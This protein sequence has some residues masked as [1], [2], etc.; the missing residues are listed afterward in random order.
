MDKQH[1]LQ[2]TIPKRYL[3]Q[4]E[5]VKSVIDPE[6]FRRYN[7]GIIQASILRACKPRELNYFN[8][9][10]LSSRMLTILKSTFVPEKTESCD[11]LI[12]FLYALAIGKLKLIK[13]DHNDFKV[14]V[15]DHFSQN[16]WVEFFAR[17]L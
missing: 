6:N 5:H 3:I 4:H 7:D 8:N 9:E 1:T 10:E 11:A 2:N 13:R 15:R 17:L 14:F 16:H 12:E